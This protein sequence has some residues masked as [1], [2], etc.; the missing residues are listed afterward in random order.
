VSPLK[1]GSSRKVISKNISEMRHAGHPQDQSVA[2]AMR[3]A[4]KPKPKGKK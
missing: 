4:G 1:K 3:M 2:A